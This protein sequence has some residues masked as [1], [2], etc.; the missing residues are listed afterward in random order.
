MTFKKRKFSVLFTAL[1]RIVYTALLMQENV[2][3]V[4]RL[5]RANKYQLHPFALKRM[6]EFLTEL[7]SDATT[8]DGLLQDLFTLLKKQCAADRFIDKAAVDTVIDMQLRRIKGSLEKDG[9]TSVQ[10]VPLDSIPHVSVEE[11][12]SDVR[13]SAQ[14]S[15]TTKL[16]AMRQRYLL[17]RSR[18]LRSGVYR[19][20]LKRHLVGDA[21]VPLLPT[22]ALEGLGPQ[23]EVGLLGLLSKQA[24]GVFL[25]D[26]YGRIKVAP[27][28]VA[29]TPPHYIGSGFMVVA[30]GR[31]VHSTLQVQRFCLP[32]AEHRGE[33]AASLAYNQDAFGLAPADRAAAMQVESRGMR[34]AITFLAHVHL[35]K[36]ATMR[37]LAF[38]FDKMQERGEQELADTTFVLA[39]NF[40]SFSTTYGDVSHLPNVFEASDTLQALFDSLGACIAT[41]APAAAQHSQFILVPGPNDLTLLQGFLPQHPLASKFVK[42]LKSRVKKVTLAPNPCRIRFYTHE[43]VVF[44]RDFLRAF[45]E[46]EREFSPPL[47]PSP[48]VS[49]VAAPTTFDRIAKTIIDEAHLVPEAQ[50]SILWKLDDALRLSVLPHTLLLCD[51]TEQWECFYKGVHVIN[52][53]SFAVNTTFL[54]YTPADGEYSLSNLE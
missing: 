40:S 26:L 31:W 24:N 41:H 51:S 53:G 13:V 44:R 6:A 32:P 16:H 33:A 17:A 43:M 38:F 14:S 36:P 10:V 1:V 30:I 52:P 2:A 49:G 37:H 46:A 23:V 28:T 5:A 29:G 18:C 20:D 48:S 45:Q 34:V 7:S 4:Q 47:T 35:D 25:E 9:T 22:T 50:E 8:S 42:G 19:G 15:N 54:W 12:T 21:L 3:E 11:T 27:P 39:G